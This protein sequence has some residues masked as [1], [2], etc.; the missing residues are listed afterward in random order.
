MSR[1]VRRSNL[2]MRVLLARS[3]L[4]RPTASTSRT[5][6]ARTDSMRINIYSDVEIGFFVTFS[7]QSGG[8]FVDMGIHD[9]SFA[10]WPLASA[11]KPQIDIGRH[12]LDPKAG[13][14][15]PAKQVNRVIAMGQQ[16]VY[17]DLVK[18]GDADN[19]WGLVE[20]ANGKILTTHLGRTTTNG[21]EGG[22]RVHGTKAHTLIGASSTINRVEIRDEYGVRTATAPDAFALYDTSFINDLAEFAGAVLDDSPLRCTPEDAFEAAKIVVALQ[23]S[24]RTRMPVY[25]DD[26]GLPILE[27]PTIKTTQQPESE[28]VSEK[29]NGT[30]VTAIAA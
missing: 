15:N 16:V 7:A 11:D 28:Q 14:S 29:L 21:Y 4:L 17:G 26:N 6:Q 9:V 27:A 3:M 12:F 24:F 5:P 19:G 30:V 22:T 1:T 23:N 25:F 8:I 13:L 20:F 18:Y 10:R 2:Q